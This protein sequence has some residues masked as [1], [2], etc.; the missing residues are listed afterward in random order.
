MG[1][2][3]DILYQP[4]Q[5]NKAA[6]ALSRMPQDSKKCM[7]SAPTL[8][9]SE[10][11]SREV[12]QD[13]ELQA[14]ITKL[15]KNPTDVPKFNWEHGRLLY[16]GRLV[17]SASSSLIPSLLQLYHD[18]VM[19]GHSGY[20]TYKRINGELY[21]KGMKKM[22]QEYV[23]QCMTCQKNKFKSLSP[24]GLLQPL[25]IPERIR[26]DLSMDFIEGLP[27]SKG[28][29]SIMVVVDRL[30]KYSHFITLSHPFSAKQV[31]AIFI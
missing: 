5:N 14:I 23:A 17:L 31:A 15:Q 2:D 19:G 27:K 30:S 29:D 3:F 13:E 10:V 4:G 7:L 22:V 21:W 25:P 24:A 26:E 28:V 12:E 18:S 6:D 20:R 8:L 1:Y 11:V 9:D 16:K